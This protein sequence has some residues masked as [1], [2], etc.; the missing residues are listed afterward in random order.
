MGKKPDVVLRKG[1]H[2]PRALDRYE[3]PDKKRK[4]KEERSCG[5]SENN[6]Q[7][8]CQA[9]VGVVREEEGEDYLKKS[10]LSNGEPQEEPGND[11]G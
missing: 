7:A 2:S 9:T 8:T 5:L 6:T 3:S 11:S 1:G 10:A 4:R